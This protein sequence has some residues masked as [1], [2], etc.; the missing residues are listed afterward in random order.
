LSEVDGFMEEEREVK[1]ME[2]TKGRE[3]WIRSDMKLF[4]TE[5][6]VM[7]NKR[8]EEKMRV[9]RDEKQ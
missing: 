5:L 2:K 3:V 4:K 9:E 7:G 8:S 6:N 1:G